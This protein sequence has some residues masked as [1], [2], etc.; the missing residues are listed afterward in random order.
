MIEIELL[1][2]VAGELFD[3]AGRGKAQLAPSVR[4][5]YFGVMRTLIATLMIFGLTASAAFAGDVPS[6]ARDADGTGKTYRLA[7]EGMMCPTN[8]APKVKESLETLPGVRSVEVDFENKQAV[9][10][11]DQ[12]IE[13]TTEACDKSFG[14]SG[15]FISSIEEVDSVAAIPAG[16]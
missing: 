15:Y 12:A 16:N 9:V 11:T 1:E 4:R 14:N 10:Q 8:C 13:L 5:S 6:A 3:R 7:V 2:H